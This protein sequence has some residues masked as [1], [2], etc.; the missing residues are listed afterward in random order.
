MRK[1]IS[2]RI[3]AAWLLL[4]VFALPFVIKSAHACHVADVQE[5]GDSHRDCADCPICHFVFASFTAAESIE[6]V[7]LASFETARPP[8]YCAPLRAAVPF[9]L[10][11]RAPPSA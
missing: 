1:A 8:D 10:P 9:I 4:A 11:A 3:I 6:E 7:I 5:Q 2:H